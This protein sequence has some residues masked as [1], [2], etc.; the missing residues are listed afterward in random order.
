MLEDLDG[1]Y[2]ALLPLREFMS[3]QY[4]SKLSTEHDPK[5]GEFKQRFLEA[6][7][8]VCIAG[9]TTKDKLY[10]D[11]ANR[12]FIIHINESKQHKSKVMEYQNKI[13]AGLIN[14]IKIKD[15]S[16]GYVLI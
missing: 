5:T 14:E 16:N 15:I 2:A 1:S 3:N 6:E 4:I 12:S 7:G 9:A 10:E 8:P 11:N 13:E